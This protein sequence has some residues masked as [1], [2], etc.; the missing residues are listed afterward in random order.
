MNLRKQMLDFDSSKEY[1]NLSA[2]Y[3]R[4]SS[5]SAWGASRRENTHSDIIAWLLNPK[6]EK[7]DHGLGDI[8][9][10]KLLATLAYVCDSLPHASGKLPA[11]IANPLLSGSYTLSSVVVEREKYIGDGRL[12][13]YIEGTIQINNAEQTLIIA[14]ENKVKSAESDS[15]TERYQNATRTL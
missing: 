5:L 9:L 6:P 12:D 3:S 7:N 15:Q 11:N 14:L 8:A 4:F 2:Y 1:K 13:I 10:R